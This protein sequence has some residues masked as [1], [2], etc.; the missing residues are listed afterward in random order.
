[1][2]S[3]AS[4]CTRAVEN[5]F[6]FAT[7]VR[8]YSTFLAEAVSVVLCGSCSERPFISSLS[9]RTISVVLRISA[10]LRAT[11]VVEAITKNRAFSSR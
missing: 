9:C 2:R 4:L 1:V 3:W 8:D 6:D 7:R 10:T 11:P 5:Q